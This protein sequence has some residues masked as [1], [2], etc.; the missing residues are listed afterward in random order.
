MIYYNNGISVTFA[1]GTKFRLDPRTYS[2]DE[3]NLISHGHSDH[4]PTRCNGKSVVMSD[5]TQTLLKLRKSAAAEILSHGAVR[6]L[7]AGHV[8]G[9]HM[10]FLEGDCSI[11]YTGDF[12]TKEKFFSQGAQPV[13]ADVLIIESTFGS[14]E[15]IFPETEK[16]ARQ[17]QDC[18]AS[19]IENDESVIVLAYPFGKAQELTHLLRDYAP[20]VDNGIYEI[21][22]A[23]ESFGYKFQHQL[24]DATRAKE[25]REPFVL[26]TSGRAKQL[27]DPD[28][29]L[30]GKKR[31]LA[32]SGW[33]INRGF[34]YFR[35]VDYAFALSDHAD[36]QD[37]LTFI[38]RCNPEVVY[39][40]HG[41]AK[42]FA[43][44]VHD[45]LG[46]ETIPLAKGQHFLTNYA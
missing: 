21:N 22:E 26:I 2:P 7:D 43:R 14:E 12:C 8:V 10:F 20:F 37:L 46:I 41:S 38:D 27:R 16:V 1:D 9:S 39:T 29:Q 24:Y 25:S 45:H 19:C 15:Y 18:V 33:A 34:K 40:C 30:Y 4:L 32:V 6:A 42:K 3:I 13:N 28:G 17:I 44:L 11:L 5:V 23:L 31:T 35:G 36:F